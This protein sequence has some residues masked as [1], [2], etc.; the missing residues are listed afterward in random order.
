[1]SEILQGKLYLGNINDI[2]NLKNINTV[3]S[4]VNKDL[5]DVI[6]T[7]LNNK[8]MHHIILADDCEY[9]DISRSFSTFQGI[10]DY[11][12]N[13]VLVHCYLGLSTSPT[14]VISYLMLRYN[15]N[16]HDS[17]NMVLKKKENIFPNDSF[18]KQLIYL[19][20]NIHGYSFYDLNKDGLNKYKKLLWGE[21]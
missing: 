20:I 15:L 16:L 9:V 2:N 12:S 21:I 13:K 17:T 7:K 19:D 14:L 8:I 5:I 11:P 4:V 6:K 3:V 18:I 1:M 10:V